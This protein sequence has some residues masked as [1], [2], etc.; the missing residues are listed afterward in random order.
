MYT[1]HINRLLHIIYSEDHAL[2]EPVDIPKP[3]GHSSV[4]DKSPVAITVATD[5]FLQDN[6]DTILMQDNPSYST[7]NQDGM[8][9]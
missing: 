9:M 8:H 1:M 7:V 3:I 2:Y 6:S 5:K 4:K